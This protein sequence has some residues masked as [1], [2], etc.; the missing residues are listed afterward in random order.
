M[1]LTLAYIQKVISDRVK[2]LYR[3]ELTHEF[4]VVDLEKENRLPTAPPPEHYEA[5][6]ILN[7]TG[8]I[9]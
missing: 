7:L 8:V 3:A 2:I 4:V 5:L 6:K 1:S 9:V